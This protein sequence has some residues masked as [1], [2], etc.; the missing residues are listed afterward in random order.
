MVTTQERLS[1]LE[2]AYEHVA[3]KQDIADVRTEIANLKSELKQ[4]ISDVRTEIANLRTELKSDTANLQTNLQTQISNLNAKIDKSASRIL[5]A[6]L[7][8]NTALIGI[9]AVI[10]VLVGILT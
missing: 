1:R 9:L 8:V 3:T 6:T 10:V 2:G 4:D 7:T 5:I